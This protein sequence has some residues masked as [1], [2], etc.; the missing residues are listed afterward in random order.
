MPVDELPDVDVVTAFGGRGP[1][2]LLPGGQGRTY[3]AGDIVI[4]PADDED[5]VT[6]AAEVLGTVD[7]D[8]FRVAR[9]IRGSGGRWVVDGWAACQWVPGEHRLRGGPWDDAIAACERFHAA[10]ADVSEPG[11]LARRH[12]RFA[13]ADRIAWGDGE[14]DLPPPIGAV[15]TRLRAL[16]RPMTACCQIVHGDF[17]G[18]LLFVDG[19]PPAVID[20]SPY[21][22]PAGYPTALT[23]V[24]AVLWYGGSVGL[25]S[26]ADHQPGLDQLLLRG[27]LFRLTLDGLLMRG[28]VPGVRWDPSQIESDVDRAEPLIAH[29]EAGRHE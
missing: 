16:V 18:N 22:R 24:D 25:I 9:P 19:L 26:R 6:W 1:V 20:F 8:G 12:H 21:W 29:L 10:V 3:R 2:V 15:A 28:N 4:K 11:F 13:E 5:E 7:E 27:L 14:I 17:A 23:I